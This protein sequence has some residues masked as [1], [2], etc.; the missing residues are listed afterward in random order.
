LGNAAQLR[1][2]D[3]T[4]GSWLAFVLDVDGFD[5]MTFRWSDDLAQTWKAAE[6][7]VTYDWQPLGGDVPSVGQAI[8]V[9]GRFQLIENQ[10]T[11]FDEPRH[12]PAQAEERKG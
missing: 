1:G 3:G 2:Y 11:G 6:V 7:P 12:R 4:A 8:D 9:R 5:P 10:C